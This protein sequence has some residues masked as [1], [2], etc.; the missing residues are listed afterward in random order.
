MFLITMKEKVD[1]IIVGLGNPS[2]QYLNTRHNI[3]WMVA[4][5]FSKKY[6]ANF[7]KESK[8]YYSATIKLGGK[9]IKV[10]LPRTFMN[11]SGLAVQIASEKYEV[12]PTNIIIICDEYNFPLGRIHLKDASGD[13]GHNGVASVIEYLKANNFMRLRCGIDRNFEDGKLVNYVLSPFNDDELE[14]RDSMVRKAVDAIEYII[15]KGK[16]RAM[17]D[18]NSGKLWETTLS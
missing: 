14:K 12:P 13:G 9:N 4:E 17:S 5:A 15:R 10:I 1:Y 2:E 18:I 11:N 8:F 6:N 16:S 7:I 3:G